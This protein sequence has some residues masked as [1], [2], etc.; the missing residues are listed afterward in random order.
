MVMLLN[1]ACAGGVS[2][3]TVPVPAGLVATALEL[4]TVGTF[5]TPGTTGDCNGVGT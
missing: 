4:G 3:E 2:V 5:V 1:C